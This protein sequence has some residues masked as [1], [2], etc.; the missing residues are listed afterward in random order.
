MLKSNKFFDFKEQHSKRLKVSRDSRK[1]MTI[2]SSKRQQ[3]V[4]K[5]M[6]SGTPKST[7]NKV[8]V[9]G[10]TVVV[11][12][13]YKVA[14]RRYKDGIASRKSVGSHAAASL[15][16]INNHGAGDLEQD[17]NLS[18]VYDEY[19]ERL[20]KEE[21][22]DL[23]KSLK[24]DEEN[25]AFRRSVI[26]IDKEDLTRE[27]LVEIVKNSMNEFMDKTENSFDF[28]FAIHTD[29]DNIHAHVIATGNA[30]D[31]MINKEQL[32]DLKL[33]IAEKTE[34]RLVEKQLEQDH[35]IDKIIEKFVEEDKDKS[36]TLNQQIDKELDGKLDDKFREEEVNKVIKEMYDNQKNHSRSLEI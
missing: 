17:E 23:I 13:N 1:R 24:H 22:K 19:G 10:S 6:S 9:Q 36:L 26:S 14:G 12:S 31:I 16:Y 35:S 2:S 8:N 28:K 15:D 20:T 7:S 32:L 5:Y 11:K 29:T 18:N 27:D 3:L 4:V 30:K 25:Q 21:F 33:T 34:E